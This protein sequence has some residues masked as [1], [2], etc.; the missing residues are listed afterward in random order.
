MNH[1][2]ENK[3]LQVFVDS[4]FVK[5]NYQTEGSIAQKYRSKI[6]T[7]SITATQ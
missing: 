1:R 7:T 3:V 6:S 4:I 2:L 5:L